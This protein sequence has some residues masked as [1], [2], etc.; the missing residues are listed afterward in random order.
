MENLS[1]L[2]DAMRVRVPEGSACS[3]MADT[4]HSQYKFSEEE[5]LRMLKEDQSVLYDTGI[6]EYAAQCGYISLLKWL[7]S[8]EAP[9]DSS[10]TAAAAET[11]NLSLLQWLIQE[12]CPLSDQACT[13]AAEQGHFQILVY[14]RSLPGLV[15]WE[16]SIVDRCGARGDIQMAEWA[17]RHGCPWDAGFMCQAVRYGH[18]HF[19]IHMVDIGIPVIVGTPDYSLHADV[20]LN[21]SLQCGDEIQ[22]EDLYVEAQH[23]GQQHIM[24]WLQERFGSQDFA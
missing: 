21:I 13:L 7:R 6:C 22:A 12:G 4:D 2:L 24:N 11:G 14:L 5:L 19:I 18:L 9:W 17:L 15:G 16:S 3:D 1:S 10:C 8:Q 23:Y 20:H